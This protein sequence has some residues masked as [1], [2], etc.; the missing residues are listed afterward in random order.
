[1][2]A[3]VLEQKT[4]KICPFHWKFDSFASVFIHKLLLQF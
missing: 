1:M 2:V 4:V 3:H